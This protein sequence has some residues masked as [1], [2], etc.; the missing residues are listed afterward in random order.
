MFRRSAVLAGFALAALALPTPAAAQIQPCAVNEPPEAAK[1]LPPAGSAPLVRCIEP[2]FHPVNQSAIDPATYIHHLRTPFSIRS[3]SK[4]VPYNEAVVQADFWNL[5][6]TNFLDNL[7]IE[8]IDEPYENGVVG[9]HVVFHMEERP[10]IKVVNYEGSKKVDVTKIEE[11]LKERGI[12]VRLDSFVDQATIRRVKGVI[13]DLYSEKGYNYSR[14]DTA[15]TPLP[16]G[17]KLMEL[18]F[19]ITEGPK[20]QIREVVF[21]G[22]KAFTDGKLRGQMKE[23]KAKSWLSFITS[24][25]TFQEAK[26]ADDAQAVTEFYGNNGYA[27]AQVGQ[28]QLETIEDSSDGSTRWIRVRIPVDEGIRYRIGKFEIGEKTSIKPEFLRPLF[29]VKEGEYYSRKKLNKGFEKAKDIYGAAGYWQM[30]PDPLMCPRGYKCD[31]NGNLEQVD[32]NPPPILDVTIRLNEGKQF[33]VNR[34]TF[35]GNTTTRD[36]VI[37]RELRVWEGQVFNTAAL[38]DSIRRL[39]QLGYFKPLEGKPEE[40]KI[41]DTPGTDNKVDITLKF[42]EQN[43][44][45]LSFGAGVSQFDGFFGQLSFQTANFLGRGE[46]V[47][48]SLQRGSQARQYQVSF[49][50]PYLFDR[51]ISVGADVFTRQYI[52]PLQYTQKTT[53]TNLIFG[54]PLADYTRLYTG[55]SFQE[56]SIF[57]IEPGYLAAAQAN[58]SPFL[59]EALLLDQGGKRTVSKVSP[60]VVFNTVNQ[61]IFPTEGKRLSASLD[62]AGLGGNT[63]FYQMRTEGIW[64]IQFTPRQSVGLRAEVQYVRPYGQTST[65]PIFEKFFLG[66]E[67]SIRGFDIRSVGPRDPQTLVVTG[68]NKTMLFNA[69][70]YLNVGGPVRLVAFYDAGQVRDL[71]QRFGWWE[72]VTQQVPPPAPLLYD[73][74][75]GY[76][77]REEGAAVPQPTTV[78]IGRRPAFKTSTGLEVRFFM[79]VLNVPFRLIAAYNPQRSGVLNN[80]LVP[81]TK[82]SFRFAVGTTF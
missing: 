20:A 64:Y 73:P 39:N 48:V 58:S 23:N 78:V 79:P 52:F 15:L 27:R 81:Q 47:G 46:T 8:V 61:P 1:N 60:S 10:R 71:G 2:R 66:G 56:I 18:T 75:T 53:G 14:V 11:T 28:P 31:D 12:E 76:A 38:K 74:F 33:S 35:L 72:D 54:L 13:A 68:G 19:N 37:R 41:E 69:E 25:G 40:M 21:D 34:I 42:E 80:N 16:D 63:S 77:V 5:W 57:D 6:R 49:S 24:A 4:W 29:K 51:A 22:N 44:N 50:E 43:R 45:Q 62:L 26:F 65:L 32:P 9:K 36:N 55:Y 30:V 82:F 59:R 67:Y 7:W 17:P 3:Q 70:Y